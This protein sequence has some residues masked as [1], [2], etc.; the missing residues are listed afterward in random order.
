MCFIEK[1]TLAAG[2]R[3]SKQR[4]AMSTSGVLLTCTTTPLWTSDEKQQ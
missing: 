3:G 4:S 2:K 1:L